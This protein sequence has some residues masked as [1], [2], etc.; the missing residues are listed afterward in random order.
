MS[1]INVSKPKLAANFKKYR[2]EQSLNIK[3]R[4]TRKPRFWINRHENDFLQQQSK[5]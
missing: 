5:K 3:N 2:V 1:M 4:L